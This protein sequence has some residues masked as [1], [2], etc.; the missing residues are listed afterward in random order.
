VEAWNAMPKRPNAYGW[1]T[2][3][4]IFLHRQ[5]FRTVDTELH[6]SRNRGVLFQLACWNNNFFLAMGL[7]PQ[8]PGDSIGVGMAWS[9]AEPESRRPL[10]R[11]DVPGI[12]PDADRQRSLPSTDSNLLPDTRR[13]A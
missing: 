3:A 6:E 12:L 1:K 13:I 5:G 7:V 11:T 8:R 2:Q 4:K 9:M 10:K